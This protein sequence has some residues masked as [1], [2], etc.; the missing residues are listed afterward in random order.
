M[1]DPLCDKKDL[2]ETIEF[3]QKAILKMKEKII[4]LKADIEN[5]IQR[6]PRDNQSI[7]Y[8]TF[9]LMFMYGM[10]TLRAK[11]SLGNEPDAMINDYLDNITYLE[12]MGEEEIGYIFLLWMVGLGILLEVDKEELKKLAKVIER[13]KTEDAL[14]DFLLKSCDIGWNH[15]TTK[16]EK[17]NPY[18]KTAEIIKIALHDKDKEAASKRLEKYMGKEWFKGHYDFGWRNA[19]KEPGYY[20]FWSFDTAALAK[21]LGLDDSALK[22]NNHYPYDL[23][24]YKN[25]MTF[26]LSWYSVPKEEEDKEEETVVYGIPGN[27]ELERI[28]PGK[29]HSFVNEIINDY[30]TLPDEEFWKKYNLKE[31]W[32]DVEEYKEDNKDKNLLG[33]IIVFMLVDKDYILQLDY[34]EELIDYIE[35]IHNYW[36]KKEVKLISFELDN[37]QQ[38]YAY[39]PKDAEVGSLYEVKLTEVEKIEEV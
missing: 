33:T 28:I 2:I 7:I 6:Y 37:D 13:R 19:H 15:S 10:S 26:D 39:V 23:A 9:K 21:I 34:K 12:N 22:N 30:K 16:Y 3:N 14:I 27:P 4:N 24:H 5:G 38:Y 35:N 18:E 17:K 32:F 1:R 29:F 31:I 25:G 8:G 20:G 11:Y 36:A